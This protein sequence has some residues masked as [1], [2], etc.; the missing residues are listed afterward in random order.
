[1]PDTKRQDSSKQYL[2]PYWDEGFAKM[3][4]TWGVKNAWHELDYLITSP[5][6]KVLDIACETGQLPI[7]AAGS[8]QVHALRPG[9]SSRHLIQWPRL[10]AIKIQ[11]I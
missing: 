4:E 1:M 11:I 3:L 5:S 7:C 2:D 10:Q 9:P 8:A 6:G